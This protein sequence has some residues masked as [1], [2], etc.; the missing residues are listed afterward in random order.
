MSPPAR[1]RSPAGCRIKSG[2]TELQG[3]KAYKQQPNLP[4]RGGVRR[5][6]ETRGSATER[7]ASVQAIRAGVFWLGRP[8][9]EIDIC[10]QDL[11]LPNP[12]PQGGGVART[13]GSA[14]KL[15][16]SPRIRISMAPMWVR[17]GKPLPLVGIRR[18]GETRGSP[19]QGWGGEFLP[20]PVQTPPPHPQQSQPLSQ[21]HPPFSSTHPP[22]APYCAHSRC[23]MDR[24]RVGPGGRKACRDL[25]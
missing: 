3:T 20:K 16:L 9:L 12:S 8:T 23:R 5:T 24:E 11:P 10:M 13:S 25:A 7:Q 14:S 22:P 18:T 17:S 19:R 2:M 4:P 21:S 1:G 15:P 6:G